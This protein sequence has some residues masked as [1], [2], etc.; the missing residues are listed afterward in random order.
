MASR[1]KL[2]V[3]WYNKKLQASLASRGPASLPALYQYD[4]LPLQIYVVEPD[5]DAGPNGTSIIP[6]S[7]K[8]LQVG[9]SGSME[10]TV[11]ASQNVFDTNTDENYFFANLA[12]NSAALDS[13]LTEDS[14]TVYFEIEMV[15]GTATT[16]LLQATSSLRRVVLTDAAVGTVPGQ[17]PVSLEMMNQMFLKKYADPGDR[18]ILPSEDEVYKTELYTGNDGSFHTDST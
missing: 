7:G 11:I 12:L 3:D 4:V 14:K 15:E 1:L 17:T 6:V 16:T 18:L 8:A 9:I 2:Y 10:G 5:P 13:F